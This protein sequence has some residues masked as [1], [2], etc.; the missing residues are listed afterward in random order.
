MRVFSFPFQ[1]GIVQS[2]ELEFGLITPP[3]FQGPFRT[4]VS[5]TPFSYLPPT[6]TSVESISPSALLP[7][8]YLP[9]SA[10]GTTRGGCVGLLVWMGIS[11]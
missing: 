7:D 10:S 8:S 9:G 4:V 11:F 1:V 5:S 3:S 6:V 2:S